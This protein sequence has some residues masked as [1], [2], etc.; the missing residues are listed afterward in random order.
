MAYQGNSGTWGVRARV[1]LSLNILAPSQSKPG[2]CDL[3]AI[4]GLI[5]F[6]RLRRDA[7][8]LLFRRERWTDEAPST[9]QE[10]AEPLDPQASSDDVPW[11]REFCS[12]PLPKCDVLPGLGEDQ[13]ELPSGPVGNTAALSCVYGQ[14]MR[15]VGP[16]WSDK[17]G[18]FSEIGA[19]L[20]TPAEH[21]V[22]D[23]LVH[24]SLVWA[25][26]PSL[27]IYSRMDGGAI[28]AHARRRRNLLAV[29]ETVY[30][31][32][33]GASALATPLAPR[34]TRLVQYA[35]DRLKWNADEFQALRVTMQYPPIP[36]AALL[37][38]ELPVRE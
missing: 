1:Q 28:H 6:R 5:G 7:Q 3:A 12:Q 32:G 26:R 19:N 21:L 4:G 38:S 20:I 25:L 24:K 35:F 15:E 13:Y 29:P 8:W 27:E 14:V 37:R 10:K 18:E 22:L 36:T 16:A 23:L 17:P 34:Y 31:A 30:D 33:S 2:M 11:V 9:V